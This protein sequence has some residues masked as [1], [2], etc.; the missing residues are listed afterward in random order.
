MVPRQVLLLGFALFLA[1][2]HSRDEAVPAKELPAIRVRVAVV[3]NK[4]HAASEDVVGTV[5]ARLAARVE[6]KINGRISQLLVAP[7]Q[8]VPR[9]A[10]LFAIDAAETQAKL[11]Q[12]NAVLAQAQK[13]FERTKPLL[14]SNAISKQDYDA[15]DAKLRVAQSAVAEAG[16][17]LGYARI[18]AP[19][20]G[21]V[22]RKIADVGDFAM[23][24]KPLLEMES[25]EGVRFEADVPETLAGNIALGMTLPVKLNAASASLNGT[26]AEIAPVADPGSRTLLVK[27]DLPRT[28]GLRSGQF[29]RVRVP[30]G[31]SHN[32]LVPAQAVAVNGQ[33]EYVRVV[34]DGRAHL[35]IVKSCDRGEG[36]VEII[37]GLAPGEQI[38]IGG[39]P[40]DGQRVEVEP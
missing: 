15:A 16:T 6:S 17:M 31:V 38:V 5:R 37:S 24:G 36:R 35:R 22:T 7:G 29:G 23:P 11:E 13:D 2:C 10:L 8:S 26:V 21:V 39:S 18:T 25:P 1:S 14:A 27:L 28:P 40:G 33:M 4:P 9:G 19:F 20:D 30:V 32:P 34:S 12:A 3:D